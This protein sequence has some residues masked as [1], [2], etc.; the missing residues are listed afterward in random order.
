MKTNTI[1]TLVLALCAFALP[2]CIDIDAPPYD[3][4]SDLTFWDDPQSALQTLNAC[5]ETLPGTEEVVYSDAATD[6]AYC[7]VQDFTRDIANGAYSPADHY[8][9]SFWDA[10]YLGIKRCNRLL[11]NINR[12]PGLSGELRNRYT[13]EAKT[14]RA[15]HYFELYSRFG[16]VPFYTHVITMS[17]A[18]TIG[19]MP[20]AD[21]AA[22]ILGDLDEVIRNND[23]P[24]SYPANEQGRI[25]RWAAYALK[26]RIL[27]F[28]GRWNDL[29]TVTDTIMTHS[30]CRLFD[31]GYAAL[32]TVAHEGNPEIILDV[33]YLKGLRENRTQAQFLPPSLGG[34]SQLSPLQELVDSYP[35]QNGK[36]IGERGSDYD[37]QQPFANRDPR[38]AATIAYDGNTYPL[39]DGSTAVVRTTPGASPDGYGFSSNCS[40]TGYYLKKYWDNDYRASLS[41][42]LNTIL[43]RYADVLLMYAEA[44]AETTG[45]TAGEWNRTIGLLRARAGFTSEGCAFPSDKTTDELI[46]I[47]RNERRCELAFEGVRLKDIYRWRIAETV[48]NGWCHG[49]YTGETIGTDNGFVRVEQRRFLPAKHYLWPIPQTDRD[50]NKNLTPNPG[51]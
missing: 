25:T 38:L 2:S 41:S 11:A 12:V 1:L 10:R 8:V 35:M 16:D 39:I 48:L 28:D 26:A 42:G 7:K 46:Q 18:A 37:A 44:C 30:G 27:L 45:L 49:L 36:A 31:G 19:R 51:W 9:K 15:W 21:V 17:E 22:A 23:L 3:R 13:G 33:Q 34:Y 20:K 4:E 6:N 43:I 29:K 47:V 5:Y 40:A 50:I 32:F 14:I 24:P